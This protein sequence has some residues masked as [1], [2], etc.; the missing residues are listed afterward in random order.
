MQIWLL[1]GDSRRDFK[2]QG[3]FCNVKMQKS[4]AKYT[5]CQPINTLKEGDLKPA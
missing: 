3:L 4:R 2:V 5:W 1:V